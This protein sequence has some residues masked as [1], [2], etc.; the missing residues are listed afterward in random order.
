MVSAGLDVGAIDPGGDNLFDLATELG[1]DL[2]AVDW[3]STPLGPVRE[4]SPSLRTT[5]RLMIGSRFAMWMG[6]GP[7]LTFFCNE[8]YRRETLGAKYPWALGKPAREV[9]SEIWDDISPRIESVLATRQATWDDGLLLFLERSGYVEETYHTFSYSALT[10]EDGGAAGLFCVVSEDTGRVIGERRMTTL[11]ELSADLA[12]ASTEADVFAAA[13]RQLAA[14]GYTLPFVL[15]Y[16]LDDTHR[17]ARLA[18]SSGVRANDPAAPWLLDLRSGDHPWAAAYPVDGTPRVVDDLERYF[19][20][21]P[22]GSWTQPP[23]QALAVP[24]TPRGEANPYGYLVV[25]LNRYRKLDTSYRGFLDIIAAQIDAAVKRARVFDAERERV[26]RLAELDRAKTTFFTNV[27]HELRTPLTLLLGPSEDAL[28]DDSYPLPGPQRARVELIARNAERLLKL[29]NTLL[30]FS[31]LESGRMRAR[32]EALDLSRYTAE[33]ASMFHSAVTRA[34]LTFVVE[35]DELPDQVWVDREMWAKIVLNLLSNA[36]KA[37]FAG[38]ITVRLSGAEAHARLDVSDTGNGI[39][40]AEQSRLFD[41]FHRVAGAQQRTHEGSGIG[42]ALVAELAALHAGSVAVRSELGVGSTFTV[43]LPYGIAHLPNA[44]VVTEAGADDG[45]DPARYSA[46]FLAEA[47]RWSNR[48]EP[49]HEQPD[50]AEHVPNRMRVLVV[51]DNDDMRN[52]VVSLLQHDYEVDVAVDGQHAL[53]RVALL[54]PD[55]VLTDVMMPRLNGFALLSELRANPSTMHLP[56]VMLSARSGDDA[57]VEGL[58]AG[59][60]DYL[61]KPFSARELRARVR[62]NLELDRVRRIA[63]ELRRSRS[64]LAD[65]EQLAHLGSVELNLQEHTVQA[66]DEWYRLLGMRRNDPGAADPLAAAIALVHPEDRSRVEDL[67]TRAAELLIPADADFR[68][69]RMDDRQRV[70]RMRCVMILDATGSALSVRASIQD[71]TDQRAAEV[72]L[73]AA[74]AEHEAAQ[75][76]HAIAEELQRS[77]LPQGAYDTGHLDVATYYRAGVEGTQVGGDWY[78]VVELDV[79]RFALVIGDV[80]GRGVRAAAVMGQLRATVRAYA[81]LDLDPADI[82]RLLD[83]AVRDINS[84]TIVTCIYAVYDPAD[85]T[86]TYANAGHLPPLLTLPGQRPHRLSAG[87]PPLGAGWTGTVAATVQL[88]PGATLTMYTDGLVERRTT[89]LDLGIDHLVDAI[90]DAIADAGVPIQALPEVLVAQLLPDGPDDD[91]ALLIARVTD[92]A[93]ADRVAAHVVPAERDAVR[94]AREFT[95]ATL[96]EWGL[97]DEA[98]YDAMLVVSELVTNAIVHGAAPVE[99]RLRLSSNQLLVDVRDAASSLPLVRDAGPDARNGRGLHIVDTLSERWGTRPTPE[100]K[101]VWSVLAGQ[102]E[103]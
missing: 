42:L 83:R 20:A 61:V 43:T 53:E 50:P 75:R 27:S 82:L 54:T 103:N 84:Y 78:D 5:V 56:V 48:P 73:A 62:A 35:C 98:R 60:D 76:E 66:S 80:M 71:V 102:P 9:W 69:T 63:D 17:S 79:G 57:A 32:F 58:E 51:D 41:R 95:D 10:D 86:L 88:P 77:L 16:L 28:T 6:Y 65:A 100:G 7:D 8:T 85:H 30:D 23:L 4:W 14:N 92:R 21:L 72:A 36:L 19:P 91:V 46:G 90:A 11:R 93:R 13:Q 31:R 70:Y 64:L 74:A 49:V 15:A 55:L 33:L 47:A 26:A 45:P 12:Q 18:W 3:A 81:R 25:G 96:R 2:A 97:P 1:R 59:A 22:F 52:Y 44:D 67:V 24:L 68:L 29:V 87:G 89:D 94:P 40:E 38:T 37:T 101:S 99:L 39:A 34:G